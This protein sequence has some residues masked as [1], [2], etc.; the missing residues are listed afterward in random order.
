MTHPINSTA[1]TRPV[2][3]TTQETAKSRSSVQ[4]DRIGGR[5]LRK[6]PATQ[7]DR[8][9]AQIGAGYSYL[10]PV[11]PS[12]NNIYENSRGGGRRKS[13]A[14]KG[15]CLEA[16]WELARQRPVRFEGRVDVSIVI[17]EPKNPSDIDNRLKP[18]LDS[19]QRCGVIRKDDNRFVR[20]VRGAW[21]A[22]EKTCRVNIWHAPEAA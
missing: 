18:I 11:P 7:N 8:P 14:Y 9:L 1:P 22:E 20:S 13:D 15:W 12:L 16:D 5:A 3:N 19:L 17:T 2:G 10:M 21:S 6:G 4:K